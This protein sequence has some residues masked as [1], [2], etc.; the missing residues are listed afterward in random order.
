P[1]LFKEFVCH[2]SKQALFASVQ[3]GCYVVQCFGFGERNRIVSS[4]TYE[5]SEDLIQGLRPPVRPSPPAIRTCEK[6]PSQKVS[7]AGALF[8]VRLGA[9]TGDSNFF[10][11]SEVRRKELGL[12]ENCVTPVVTRARHL[13]AA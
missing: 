3:E 8:N 11:L 12:P 6:P 7:K 5:C 13:T 2:R 1:G 9:V 10:L 4:H